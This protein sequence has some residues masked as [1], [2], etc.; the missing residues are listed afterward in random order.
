MK[1]GGASRLRDSVEAAL[2]LGDGQLEHAPA[3]GSTGDRYSV[4]RMFLDCSVGLPDLSPALGPIPEQRRGR[5][6]KLEP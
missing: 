1:A 3:D 6:R 2:R 4:H 5:P